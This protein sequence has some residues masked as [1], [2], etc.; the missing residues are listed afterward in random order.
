MW[1]YTCGG[2]ESLK[3]GKEVRKIVVELCR[4]IYEMGTGPRTLEILLWY[5]SRRRTIP[6]KYE[7]YR[8][9][10]LIAYI[11]TILLRSAN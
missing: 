6:R 7:A 4:Q 5:L 3:W 1:Q 10:S 11:A 2:M 8:T 9:I